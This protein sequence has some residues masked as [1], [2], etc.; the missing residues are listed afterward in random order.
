[1][2]FSKKVQ[3]LNSSDIIVRQVHGHEAERMVRERSA[4]LVGRGRVVRAIRICRPAAIYPCR[5]P[6]PPTN[7]SYMGQR[8]TVV[9]A[10]R[11]SDGQV[12]SHTVALRKIP[13]CDRWVFVLSVTD[14]LPRMSRMKL[15]TG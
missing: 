15:A 2:K 3:L 13:A 5:A 12:D 8:Y 10:L 6:Q 7:R 9:E 4:E 14:C 1:M 11:D